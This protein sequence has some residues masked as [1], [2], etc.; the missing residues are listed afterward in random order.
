MNK[1]SSL[2][3]TCIV[4]FIV[5]TV[6]NVIKGQYA[7]IVFFILDLQMCCF[8]KSLVCNGIVFLQKIK[9]HTVF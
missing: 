5:V 2:R 3:I 1:D 7:G 8:N 6:I 4:S 9:Y